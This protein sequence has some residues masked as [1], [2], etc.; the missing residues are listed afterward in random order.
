[1]LQQHVRVEAQGCHEVN[2]V[3]RRLQEDGHAGR[4][5]EPHDELEGEPD[6]A[7]QLD[8]E[9]GL[10]GERLVLV[11]GPVGGVLVPVAVNVGNGGFKEWLT[12]NGWCT[13]P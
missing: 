12:E 2:P 4:D 7:H 13:C 8:V 1:M 5:H 3:E 6:V 11:Q 9:E 10:V